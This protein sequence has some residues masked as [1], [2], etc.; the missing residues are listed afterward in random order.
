MAGIWRRWVVANMVGELVGFGLAGIVLFLTT[1]LIAS[2]NGGVLW[3]P[4]ILAIALMGALEGTAVAI[5]QWAVLGP[6]F[7]ALTR[8]AWLVATVAGAIVAWGAGMAI[9]TNAGALFEGAS[10]AGRLAG[11]SAI[12]VVAGTIL[13][14]PQWL[15]LERAGVVARWWV[16]AHAAA[17]ALGMLVAFAGIGLVPEDAEIGT[18][19]AAA[20]ATGVVMGAAVAAVSGIALVGAARATPSRSPA[21]P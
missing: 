21:S 16:P 11:G 9:G 15:A 4:A 19:A 5:A 20:A 13:A 6:L 17:W 2:E 12:G 10:D 8:R 7:V 18:V 1:V 3:I 14:S